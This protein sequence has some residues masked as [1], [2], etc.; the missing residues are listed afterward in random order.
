MKITLFNSKEKNI[1][2]A[3][4]VVL[5]RKISDL[6]KEEQTFLKELNFSKENKSIL[7]V[8]KNKYYILCDSLKQ[9]SVK[10]TLC[11]V[12]RKLTSEGF[13][14]LVFSLCTPQKELK[15]SSLIE[16][17]VLGNYSFTKYKSENKKTKMAIYI[18]IKN[19]KKEFISLE[20]E[21]RETLIICKNVNFV[22]E[23]NNT[24]A[25]DYAPITM[26]EDARKIAKE[27]N[28]E[29]K[30]YGEKDLEKMNMNVMLAVGRASRHE[31]QLIHLHY[32][33]KDKSLGKIVL[34]GKGLTYD[35]GGLSLKPTLGMLTMKRDKTGGITVLGI[36][37]ALRELNYPYEVHGIIGAVENMIGGDAFKPGD[38]LYAKNKVSIE[39]R[40][41]DAEG[42]LVL[43][44]CLCYAQDEIKDIDCLINIATLTGAC[45]IA[46]GVYTTGVMA[47]SSSLKN[48]MQKASNKSGELIG[49]LPFNGFLEKLIN[50]GI[51]DVSNTGS[52]PAGGAITAA[53]FLDKFIKKRNKKKWLHL[54]MAGPA[55]SEVPWAYHSPGASGSGLRLLLNFI[56]HFKKQ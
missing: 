55:Y 49:T 1:K 40:N 30:I 43:A 26:S 21:L 10:I 50:S 42:R 27:Y 31:S 56:K 48:K 39:V 32:I 12:L 45:K 19:S 13:K 8:E 5:L 24:T 54:D 29:C 4:E 35:C 15:L 6:S 23:L 2:K 34:V 17:L 7:L 18:D 52:S 3:L 25:E 46:L 9:E 28:L 33:P 53:L 51:A 41:T 20:K 36:L 44:D 38:V 22:R 16:G 11:T 47:H 37:G 14:K